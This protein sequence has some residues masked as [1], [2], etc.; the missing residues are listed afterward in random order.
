MPVPHHAFAVPFGMPLCTAGCQALL[1]RRAFVH[2]HSVSYRCRSRLC[3]VVF[4]LHAS[5]LLH[6]ASAGE[7]SLA[8]EYWCL[9]TM[10]TIQ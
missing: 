2:A 6:F 1:L 4:H 10:C 8:Q 5:L 9:C 7:R 3:A